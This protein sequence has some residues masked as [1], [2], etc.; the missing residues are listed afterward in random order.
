MTLDN[1]KRT[2]AWAALDYIPKGS[3]I[4]V[5]SGSTVT[6]FIN[7]LGTLKSQIDG[8]VSSSNQSSVQLKN[9]GIP[10]INCNDVE[11][12]PIYID[13]TDE[14]NDQLQL[15]KGGGA[16]LTKEKV[17]AAISRKFICIADES[18]HVSLLGKF[19][20]PLE[21]IPMARSYVA[22]EILKLGLG[23][24][25]TYRRGVVT[26][27]GNVILDIHHIKINNPIHLEKAIKMIAGVVTV[28][29]FAIRSADIALIST[30]NGVKYLNKI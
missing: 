24:M 8:V 12:L 25:P 5:G 13:G 18:K 28:G 14:I 1:L 9:L 23:G 20:L 6:H 17:I 3:I 4:G 22:R 16:A 26:E 27:N 15:I 10:V 19:P 21:V 30:F 11:S 7:A 29:L 2:V